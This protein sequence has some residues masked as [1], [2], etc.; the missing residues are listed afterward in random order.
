M[1][2]HNICFCEEIR[3]IIPNLSKLPLL[4]WST[5]RNK[6]K[7]VETKLSTFVTNNSELE[8]SK[9]FGIHVLFLHKI[10][11]RFYAMV[12]KLSLVTAGCQ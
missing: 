4:I 2:G 7:L 6:N 3:L 9:N 1:M 12:R 10:C 5:E 11:R 8:I